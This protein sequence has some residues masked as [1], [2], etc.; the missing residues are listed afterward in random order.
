MTMH[1]T[2]VLL[3]CVRQVIRDHPLLSLFTLACIG[4]CIPVSLIPALIMEDLVNRL[5]SGNS[6]ILNPAVRWIGVSVLA[7]V[8]EAMREGMITWIGQAVLHALRTMLSEKL[9]RLETSY[10]TDHPSGEILSVIVNDTES[11]GSLFTGGIV[12][13]AADAC[14]IIGILYVICTRSMGLFVI[15]LVT[16]PV[17]FVFTRLVQRRMLERQKENRQAKAGSSAIVPETVRC[18]STIALYQAQNYMQERF[19]AAIEKGYEA[20]NHVSF[21]DAVYSPVIVSV[22]SILIGCTMTLIAY[23]TGMRSWFGVSVGTGVALI[24]Y[25]SQIFGPLESLGQ[26]IQSIQESGACLSRLDAFMDLPE[27]KETVKQNTTDTDIVFDH[28]RFGYDP[29]QPV[30]NDVSLTIH[31]GEHVLVEGRT[32]SG[33]STLFALLQGLYE[34]QDGTVSVY[35][36]DPYRMEECTRRQLFGVVEQKTGLIEGTL[37]DQITLHR[38]GISEEMLMEAVETA[39]LKDYIQALPDGLK[40]EKE[41]LALSDGQLQLISIAR[42]VVMK[43]VILLLDEMNASIDANTE[44]QVMDALQKASQGRTVISI[45]HRKTVMHVDR[46]IDLKSLLNL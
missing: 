10:F 34:P 30:L 17:V 37:Q 2:H 3:T 22:S 38:P 36:Y 16:L 23:N 27:R 29:D 35:G 13:M 41:D 21:Y 26:E 11:A 42:A 25:I 6:M 40:T 15:L 43:P 5:V 39:G 24:T 9:E 8:L 31:K 12:S 20:M 1:K 19:D 46:V 33:K 14:S 28:V 32:G 7:C 18:A 4:I 45:A 44:Q